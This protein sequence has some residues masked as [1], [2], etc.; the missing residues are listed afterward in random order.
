MGNDPEQKLLRRNDMKMSKRF[1]VIGGTILLVVLAGFGVFAAWGPAGWSGCGPSFG[2]CGRGFHNGPWG[3]G[4]MA[5]F[6]LW[7]IDSKIEDLKLTPL[8]KEK[9]DELRK[10]VKGHLSSAREEREKLREVFRSEVTKESPDVAALTKTMKKKIQDVSSVM[11]TDLDLVA[12]FYGSL[13]NTQ[14]QKIMSA[15]RERM[16]TRGRCMERGEQL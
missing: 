9:Y 16:A 11:Q 12:A 1:M 3:K 4:E 5:E 13:D 2:P 8:Q 15:I 14:K 10:S 7:R 6:V